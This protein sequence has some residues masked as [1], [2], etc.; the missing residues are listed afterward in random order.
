MSI[1][2]TRIWSFEYEPTTLKE[3]ILDS[4]IKAKLEKAIEELPNLLLYGQPGVGK[5]TFTHILL[6]HTGLEYK[7]LNASDTTGIDTIRDIVRP[8]C[9]AG[10]SKI[11]IVIFN[12][13]DSLTSGPQGAQKMLRQLIEDVQGIARFIFLANY[14]QNIIPEIKS[15]CQTITL[16][17][18]PVKEIGLFMSRI[19]KKEKIKYDSKTLVSIIK[20]CYPDIRKTIWTIQ[21]N[22]IDGVLVDT[23]VYSTEQTFQNILKAIKD[24][25]IDEIRTLIK[26]NY[27]NYTQLY[28]YLYE[29]VGEFDSPGG[30]I[31]EIADHIRWT[32][33]VANEEI[34]FMHMIM[35]MYSSKIIC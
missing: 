21:E 32:T 29:N 22:S 4:V 23:H 11:K 16:D 3:M 10:G 28:E 9:F 12:E 30:A 19:L 26:K 17:N 5:G 6:R 33:T 1:K 20:K 31:I 24:K 14:V 34:N 35:R 15:R 13:A 18:P 7:W 27:I 8:Y 25:D 2:T